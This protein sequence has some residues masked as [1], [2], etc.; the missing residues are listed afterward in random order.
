MQIADF[1]EVN[2]LTFGDFQRDY[3]Y[4]VLITVEPSAPG[5]SAAKGAIDPKTLDA[6]CDAFPIPNSKQSTLRRM[7]AGRW[8]MGSSKLDSANTVQATFRYD[9]NN[10]LYQYLYAWN[11]LTG[12][13]GGG[14]IVP[15]Y[16]YVGEISLVLYKSDKTSIGKGYTLKKAF[17]P[18]LSDLN[19]DKSK[20]GYLSF[21]ATIAYDKKTPYV[22]A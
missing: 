22:P 10:K 2:D 14:V 12:S 15:K 19:L 5:F 18:E 1:T 17:I 16:Q 21:T 8:Y 13:D 3:L 6:F 7:W 11:Q 20:D 4:Q 9:E